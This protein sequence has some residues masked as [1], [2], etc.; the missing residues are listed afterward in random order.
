LPNLF[1]P[2]DEYGFGISFVPDPLDIWKFP[3]SMVIQDFFP[4]PTIMTGYLSPTEVGAGLVMGIPRLPLVM[5]VF[6]MRPDRNGWVIGE[7][8]SDLEGLGTDYAEDAGNAVSTNSDPPDAPNNLVDLL[9][10]LRLGRFGIGVG[11]GFSYDVALW[12]SGDILGTPNSDTKKAS[13]SWAAPVRLGAGMDLNPNFPLSVDLCGSLIFSRYKAV[14]ES[15]AA[16]VPLSNENDSVTADNIC[17]SVGGRLVWTLTSKLDLLVIGEYAHFSQDYAATDDG[18]ALDTSTTRID[19]ASFFSFSGGLGLNWVPSTDRFFNTLLS[20]TYGDGHWNADAPAPGPRGEGD[21]I[22][23]F[24]FRLVV[25]GEIVLAS[26][27][28]LRGGGGATL[29]VYDTHPG[30]TLI[31]IV[32]TASAGLGF[33]IGETIKLELSV[34]FSDWIN[35]ESARDGA[36]RAS[37]EVRL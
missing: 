21:W 17:Y 20:V 1:F 4:S 13:S 5:G 2:T 35:D 25:D 6:Y 10:A 22:N 3:Q 7:P 34:D 9:L 18:I 37:T 11:G 19:P 31:E 27:L 28:I 26:W 33:L 8:R 29:C 30:P 32:P 36:I 14:Y 16:A 24:T 15:S 12:Y 23:W